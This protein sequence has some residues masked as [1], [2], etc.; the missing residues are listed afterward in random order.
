MKFQSGKHFFNY[1][2]KMLANN[3]QMN[4]KDVVLD[5]DTFDSIYNIEDMA[6]GY[7]KAIGVGMPTIVVG[8]ALQA[9][10]K[11]PED[12]ARIKEIIAPILR[13]YWGVTSNKQKVKQ[14]NKEIL[15]RW[16]KAS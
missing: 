14:R 13:S 15:Q 6:G 11:E 12:L 9:Q 7:Y 16:Y 3:L 2:R 1:I 10:V 8:K 4:V 5:F